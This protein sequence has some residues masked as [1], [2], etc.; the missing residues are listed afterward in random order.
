MALKII[1]VI[2]SG[3]SGSRL[4]PLSRAKYPKQLLALN[5]DQTLLQETVCR[6]NDIAHIGTPIIVCNESHRFLVA[7]QMREINN[8]SVKIIL[9]PVGRNTAPALTIAALTALKGLDDAVLAVMPADHV[10]KDPQ[11]FQSALAAA[12]K[13]AN[14]DR[15][16]TFGVQ[17]TSPETGYGYIKCGTNNSVQAFVEKPDKATAKKYIEDSSYFWNSGMFVMKASVWLREL[18]I[19]EKEIVDL[20][21]EA[22]KTSQNDL[23]FIRINEKSFAACKNISIDYAVMEKTAA[24]SVVPLVAGWSDIGSWSSLAEVMKKDDAGN[25]IEGDC[26]TYN[27]ENSFLLSQGRM[28]ATV[29]LKDTIVVETAD[30]VL[31]ANK[32]SSQDVKEIVDRLKL[33]G[34]SQLHSHTKVYRPWGFYQT[35]DTGLQFQVKRINV[36]PGAALSLQKHQRRAEHWVVVKGQ[37]DIVRGD[38]K[39]ILKENESTYIPIG[40]MHRL[41]NKTDYELE[42]IEV[43]SGDYL[44]EDDIERFEDLY[45]RD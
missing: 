12:I 14:D 40:M 44:D 19:Y 22:L 8:T 42:I 28:I 25:Y 36:K 1:P 31:V 3:G 16:V 39:L 11:S 34:R 24:A 26:Y 27:T 41:E 30:A 9:E 18:E 6:F 4:W 45:N 43:Q 23:D 10:I 33:E 37:A 17:P 38:E 7:E 32:N 2:L 35:V 15:L 5:T 29:G 21:K 13:L 20:C